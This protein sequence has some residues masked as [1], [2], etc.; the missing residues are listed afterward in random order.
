MLKLKN[1]YDLDQPA[2]YGDKI[3]VVSHCYTGQRGITCLK[4]DEELIVRKGE[5]KK[6]HFCHRKGS[7]CVLFSGIVGEGETKEHKE[8]KIKI[9]TRFNE[10]EHMTIT[11]KSCFRC[12]KRTML[13]D[14]T[15][16]KNAGFHAVI[17][18]KYMDKKG[19]TRWADVAIIDNSGNIH[20]IIEI[21]KSH[22][23]PEQNREGCVWVELSAFS[24]ENN[25]DDHFT[26]V[27]IPTKSC[28]NCS[29]IIHREQ[30]YLKR[31]YESSFE[32]E[33]QM[34]YK[35]AYLFFKSTNASRR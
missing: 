25:V 6:H 18:Y 2:R 13:H 10:S 21:L 31:I 15:G 7:E 35:M 11:Q 3:V 26:C 20:M 8:A 22:A 19:V 9:A 28:D 4:C 32:P 14:L 29:V 1:N 16:W 17:E 30:E 5:Q 23:T 27:R 12:E 33:R 34:D 24:V